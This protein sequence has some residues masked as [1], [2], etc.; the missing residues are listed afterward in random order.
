MKRIFIFIFSLGFFSFNAFA[1]VKDEPIRVKGI[2]PMGMGGAFAAI[3][4]DENAIHYNPA[5]I[6]QRQKWLLQIFSLN[7]LINSNQASAALEN[8][9]VKALRDISSKDS[10]SISVFAI[11]QDGNTAFLPDILF[12]SKPI[13]RGFLFGSFGI[14]E[15]LSIEYQ[16]S[17]AVK[18]PHYVVDL[19]NAQRNM[20]VVSANDVIS[21]IPSDILQELGSGLTIEQL[22]S[23]LIKAKDGD[24]TASDAIYASFNND[25]VKEF[26]NDL[27]KGNKNYDDI[28]AEIE[29]KFPNNKEEILKPDTK[30]ADIVNTYITGVLDIP[31]AFRI[32]SFD[33]Q[34]LSFG[35]NLKL[36]NRL[37]LRQLVTLNANSYQ[38]VEDNIETFDLAA[39]NGYGY[40]IDLGAIYHFGRQFNIGVQASDIFTRIYYGRL[41]KKYGEIFPDEDAYI[42]Q[43]INIGAAF[44][45]N[46]FERRLTIAADMRDLF[47][48]YETE[49]IKKIHIGAEYRFSPFALRIGLNKFYPSLGVGIELNYFQLMFAFYGDD[50]YLSKE[51]EMNRTIY[52]SEIQIS[53]KIGHFRGRPFGKTQ[54]EDKYELKESPKKPAVI[55]SETRSRDKVSVISDPRD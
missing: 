30:A 8:K 16:A 39:F 28:I 18:T 3:A 52:Y 29:R 50:N 55:K 42:E 15:F 48:A 14:G 22:D 47:S 31:I 41:D 26:I 13:G 1:L 9:A 24:A 27:Q 33:S 7:M 38:K 40:G 51:F 10:I 45:P 34:A 25:A 17:P 23:L 12:I 6:T 2:R 54:A 53:A 32:G 49:I 46:I 21:A 19:A 5:G 36:I 37:K 43:Q 44:T 35:A 4:D 11:N 20:T